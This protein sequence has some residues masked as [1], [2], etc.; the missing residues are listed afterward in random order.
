MRRKTASTWFQ[1]TLGDAYRVIA[2]TRSER[3]ALL[4]IGFL[5][6]ILLVIHSASQP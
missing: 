5:F 6:W 1:T 4:A 2:S 3:L